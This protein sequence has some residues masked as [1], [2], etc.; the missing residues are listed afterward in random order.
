MKKSKQEE[1]CMREVKGNLLNATESIIAHQVNC[2]G[3]MGAGVAYHIRKE[4]LSWFEYQ[5]YQRTCKTYSSQ[6]LLGNIIVH[7]TNRPGTYVIDLFGEDQPT[8]TE[9]DTDYDALE[10]AL[11]KAVKLSVCGGHTIA[12]PGYLGCGLAGGDWEIVYNMI[13]KIEKKYHTSI[14]LY[15]I[16]KSI[17]QLWD[18]FGAIPMEPKTE[19]IKKEWHGFPDGTHREE[20]WHW[21]E[22][23][24]D[25]SVAENL[26]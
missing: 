2:K 11:D 20:I 18:D 22:E 17:K 3:V 26:M 19:C 24:F 6:D 12:L 5:R 25:V 23:T 4:L 8:K 1:I 14:T 7:T 13:K 9:V 10:S 15:Y 16:D 21:F